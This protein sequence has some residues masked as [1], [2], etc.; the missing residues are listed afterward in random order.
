MVAPQRPS[1]NYNP[2]NIS[3]E[4][5]KDTVNFF[6]ENQLKKKLQNSISFRQILRKVRSVLKIRYQTLLITSALS[7][8]TLQR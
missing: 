3:L 4:L 1:A 5:T 2:M 6:L 8:I 7:S